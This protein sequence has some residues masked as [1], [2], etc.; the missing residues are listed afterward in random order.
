MFT[1]H[2]PSTYSLSL[3]SRPSNFLPSSSSPSG[4][5]PS[6]SKLHPLLRTKLLKLRDAHIKSTKT[7][8]TARLLTDTKKYP[9]ALL[10]MDQ[11]EESEDEGSWP[12]M[13]TKAKRLAEAN[14]GLTPKE[15]EKPRKRCSVSWGARKYEGSDSEGE[16]DEPVDIFGGN[17]ER[18]LD[19]SDLAMLEYE[20]VNLDCA[21]GAWRMLQEKEKSRL[22]KE[23]A[24]EGEA[25]PTTTTGT[26][27]DV[28]LEKLVFEDE[29]PSTMMD[30]MKLGSSDCSSGSDEEGLS[31]PTTTPPTSPP[32]S[33]KSAAFSTLALPCPPLTDALS[34]LSLVRRSP[35]ST[36]SKVL[37]WKL[38]RKAGRYYGT[39]RGRKE[40]VSIVKS[41]ALKLEVDLRVAYSR[42]H[43]KWQRLLSSP[44]KKFPILSYDAVPWPTMDYMKVA[45]TKVCREEIGRFLLVG[46]EK[47]KLER[48]KVFGEALK[49]WERKRFEKLIVPWEEETVKKEVLDAVEVVQNHIESLEE[50]MEPQQAE[51]RKKRKRVEEEAE[52]AEA[53]QRERDAKRRR[54]IEGAE[55][56]VKRSVTRVVKSLRRKRPVVDVCLH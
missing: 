33:P 17:L 22:F 48:A 19:E 12:R 37:Q 42:Y 2:N 1:P 45:D 20:R 14:A 54:L 53:E 3:F 13:T 44:L 28:E 8:Y 35:P 11:G 50:E 49:V 46:G 24:K 52:R 25:A 10:D 36:P 23:K 15:K 39:H 6:K 21:Q 18:E 47:Q 16:D 41:K 27:E 9:W 4:S 32:S 55:N 31:T 34:Q 40:R 30:E 51:M 5:S 38:N 26:E 29:S 43:A 56:F 7:P